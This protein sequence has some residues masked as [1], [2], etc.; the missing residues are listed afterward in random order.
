VDEAWRVVDEH[1]RELDLVIKRNLRLTTGSGGGW[2]ERPLAGTV[3]S[4]LAAIGFASNGTGTRVALPATTRMAAVA[5][6]LR[7]NHR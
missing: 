6:A 5:Y 7:D 4:S 1:E 2:E 3:E